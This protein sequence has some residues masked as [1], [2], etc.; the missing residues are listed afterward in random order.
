VRRLPRYWRLAAIWAVGAF[1]FCWQVFVEQADRP[2]VL[3]ASL[4]LMGLPFVVLGAP[5]GSLGATARRYLLPV[6]RAAARV[7]A[8]AALLREEYARD[9]MTIEQFEGELDRAAD[10]PQAPG[11]RSTG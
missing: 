10:A 1:G 9:R 8:R 7:E 4:T 6:D 11:K 2:S 5:A 3:V